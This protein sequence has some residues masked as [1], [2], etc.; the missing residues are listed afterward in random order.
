MQILILFDIMGAAWW[1]RGYLVQGSSL[2][3][4][5]LHVE[6]VCS[7]LCGFSSFLPHFKNV[8][9][10]SRELSEG[11][12]V[13]VNGCLSIFGLRLA[14]DQLTSCLNSPW[15]GSNVTIHQECQPM[16]HLPISST[17]NEDVNQNL[18][19]Q[20]SSHPF[21]S[22]YKAIC[23]VVGNVNL[24]DEYLTRDQQFISRN[25]YVDR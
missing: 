1:I 11:L 15:I 13:S 7:S 3:P 2:P 6:F 23:F 12:N 10:S 21:K 24:T 9:I 20:A 19:T 18:K 22:I 5:F 25:L 4:A 16:L 8:H 17:F 14:D